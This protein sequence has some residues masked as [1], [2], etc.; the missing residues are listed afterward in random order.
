MTSTSIILMVTAALAA[1][2][3]ATQPPAPTAP[4]GEVALTLKEKDL[5]PEGIAQDPVTGAFFLGST[6]KRKIVTV[7][8]NG[9]ERDFAPHGRD[10]L[11]SVMGLRVDPERRHLW[12]MTDGHERIP[13][14][15]GRA[16]AF[17]YD[18]TTGKLI[19]R[20]VVDDGS[21]KHL[22]ND[23]AITHE[24]EVYIT[25]SA[26][27][28]L[29]RI[30]PGKDELERFLDPNTIR[31][32]NG[33]TVSD[34]GKSLFV[35]HSMGI[36]VIDP[37]T[38]ASRDIRTIEGVTLLGIDGLYFYRGSLVGIQ[39]GARPERVVRFFLTPAFDRVERVQVLDAGNPLFDVPTTGV[40]AGDSFYYIANS[41]VD[42]FDS[43]GRIF[44]L[45]KL[46][47][48]VILKVKLDPP[49]TTR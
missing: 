7:G 22:F 5:I 25:D 34:D 6:H 45:N 37:Q 44:P 35:A 39:N 8:A 1:A 26:A 47:E 27:G 30:T 46:K 43:M 41:Q 31:Y 49:A 29:Y 23:V 3:T 10:G 18:L 2:Q 9:A 21:R 24:G 11:W 12:A 4:A 36:A 42:S 38:K 13:Q 14:E 48:P 20:Y 15:K 28:T 19:S 32:P 17:K 40:I 33:I 16:G